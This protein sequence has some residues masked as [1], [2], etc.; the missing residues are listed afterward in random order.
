MKTISLR[1]GAA[2]SLCAGFL[3]AQDPPSVIPQTVLGTSAIPVLRFGSGSS[4]AAALTGSGSL[5]VSDVPV[6]PADRNAPPSGGRRQITLEQVKQQQFV[7]PV[8]SSPMARLARLSIE[9]AK[10]HR[11]GAQADYFPKLNALVTNLHFDQFLGSLLTIQRP[12]AGV[13]T[14]VPIAIFNQNQTVA[15]ISFVQP[16]TP[17]F[18]VYQLVKI[19]RADERIAMAKAGVPIAKNSTGTRLAKSASDSQI[20]ESYLK[21]LIAQQKVVSEELKFRATESRPLFAST[22]SELILASGREPDLH[23]PELMEVKKAI[24][25]AGNEVKELTA[26]LNRL[27]GWPEDTQLELVPP[28]PLVEN[29][30]L[31]DVADQP[32]AGNVDLIEAEQTAVKARAASVLSKLAYMP[33]VAAVAGFANQNVIPAVPSNIGYGGV[34]VTYNVFDFGKREHAVKEASAQLGMALVAVDL[35]K[36]KI[37]ATMKKT[38]FELERSRQLSQVAQQMGSSVTRLINVSSTSESP[39]IKAVRTKVELEML[40]ADLAHRQAYAR[41]RALMGGNDKE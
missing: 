8:D 33:T 29:I 19:A 6:V 27:M 32:A 41:M 10:Q 21:L 18:Q 12:I 11:L 30:S 25:V 13:T 7:A 15:S 17:L 2:I 28:E 37:A 39:D 20:E 1:L 26:S 34:M 36:A 31:Q 3:A 22:S 23:T 9:A 24:L 35:T 4:S 5:Q 38:Y 16:I 14:Q 40:E